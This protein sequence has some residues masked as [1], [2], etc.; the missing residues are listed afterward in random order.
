MALP[1]NVCFFLCLKPHPQRPPPPSSVVCISDCQ[2]RNQRIGGMT[3]T[4]IIVPQVP[5]GTRPPPDVTNLSRTSATRA[6]PGLCQALAH[7]L[8]SQRL[9][10]PAS[11]PLPLGQSFPPLYPP[12]SCSGRLGPA[13][14]PC[15]PP[16]CHPGDVRPVPGEEGPSTTKLDPGTRPRHRGCRCACAACRARPD[17]HPAHRASLNTYFCWKNRGSVQCNS[18]PSDPYF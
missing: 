9:V 16:A 3:S 18:F 4:H 2:L 7:T 5:F 6:R 8:R 12:L 17:E 10:P 13:R 1:K 15:G 14:V 11:V